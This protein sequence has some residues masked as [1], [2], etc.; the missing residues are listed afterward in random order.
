MTPRLRTVDVGIAHEFELRR[1]PVL[2][3]QEVEAAHLVG[4]VI[5]AVARSDAAVVDH[6]VQAFAAVDGRLHGTNQ[7]AGSVL[8]LHAG[9]RLEESFGIVAWAL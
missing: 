1:F 6:V 2:E 7:F 8:A 4:T 3:E 9:H 5:R